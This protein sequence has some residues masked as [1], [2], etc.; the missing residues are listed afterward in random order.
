LSVA[1]SRLVRFSPR[2][3]AA[4]RTPGASLPSLTRRAGALSR[5]AAKR[6]PSTFGACADTWGV[7]HW[8]GCGLASGSECGEADGLLVPA[9][10]SSR[11]L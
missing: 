2:H 11:L 5:H 1:A 4:Q 10:Q 9:N 6:R 8:L 3:V 7:G